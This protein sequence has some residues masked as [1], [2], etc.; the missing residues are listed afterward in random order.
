MFGYSGWVETAAINEALLEFGAGSVEEALVFL[1][2]RPKGMFKYRRWILYLK[3]WVR[4]QRKALKKVH[5]RRAK[6]SDNA[7]WNTT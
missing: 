4:S 2:K 5:Q 6:P 7:S 3:E 1:E